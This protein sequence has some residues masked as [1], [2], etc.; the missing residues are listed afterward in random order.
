MDPD[1]QHIGITVGSDQQ[2]LSVKIMTLY[3]PYMVKDK[4]RP[5]S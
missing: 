5:L 4:T 2:H 3:I 1:L